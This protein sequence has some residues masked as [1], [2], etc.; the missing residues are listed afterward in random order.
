M[1]VLMR[2]GRKGQRLHDR[3]LGTRV[4]TQ[5]AASDNQT[6]TL[7]DSSLTGTSSFFFRVMVA[8]P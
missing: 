3:L 8:Y 4:D 1:L 5:T 7:H 2:S 6:I